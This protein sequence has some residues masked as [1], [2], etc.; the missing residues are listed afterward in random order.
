[1]KKGYLLILFALFFFTQTY[2]QSAKKSP[3]HDLYDKWES[4]RAPAIS[5]NGKYVSYEVQPGKGDGKLM[6]L[7]TENNTTYIVPRGQKAVFAD[8]SRFLACKVIPAA[9]DTRK[10]KKDK[11]KEDKMPKD[12]LVIVSLEK[13][14]QKKSFARVSD[15]YLP[16]ENANFVA[17]QFE[18]DTTKE[19]TAPAD[20][21]KPEK[22]KE[23]ASKKKKKPEG[24]KLMYYF[25]ETGDSAIFSD[26]TQVAISKK[27]TMSGFI[28]QF[29]DSIDSV[30][31]TLFNPLTKKPFIRFSNPGYG[32][33]I[34]FS[35]DGTKYAFL[36]SSDTIKE[37]TYAL[38]YATDSIIKPYCI[39]DTQ[40][41][42]LPM[43]WSPS[44]NFNMYF[45]EDGEKLVFGVAPRPVIIPKDTLLE[46]EKVKLDI[47]SWNDKQIQPQQLKNLDQEKKRTYLSIFHTSTEK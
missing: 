14:F 35:E 34:V 36:F 23:S 12:S 29:G 30:R 2:S 41:V 39:V 31:I 6:I 4:L 46:E 26:V 24:T 43:S 32:K 44:E 18:K 40:V 37:K 22:K 3:G 1:M 16:K 25:P 19:K 17:I 7:K 21:T 42:S 10:A 45:S 47:W 20:S 28:S 8:N 5:D 13:N 11:L 38:Y 27:G 9:A 15:F 33:N